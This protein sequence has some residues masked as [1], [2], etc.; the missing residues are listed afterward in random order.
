MKKIDYTSSG[1]KIDPDTGEILNGGNGVTL[2]LTPKIRTLYNFNRDE[3][4]ARTA[5]E[6]KE[7][8]RTQQQ[9][10]DECNINNIMKKFGITGELP[11]NIRPVLPDEYDEITDYTSAMNT[12]RRAQEAFMEMPSGIR[13]RFQNNPQTFTEFFA[14]PDNRDEALK[15]GLILPQKPPTIPP[16]G[17][18]KPGTGEPGE[19]D[20]GVT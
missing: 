5:T 7:P 18:E 16:G 17:T 2:P 13:A 9:F 14:N 11:M 8:T 1:P 15:M 3:N 4:T 6:C 10:R 19:G 20:K 12:I